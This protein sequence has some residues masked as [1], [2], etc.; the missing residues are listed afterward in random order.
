MET[1]NN[2]YFYILLGIGVGIGVYHVLCN[3]FKN[4][5]ATQNKNIENK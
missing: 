3:R 2:R 4:K 1:K 5:I